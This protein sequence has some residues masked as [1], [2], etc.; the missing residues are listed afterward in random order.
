MQRIED[1]FRYF[2][3][4]LDDLKRPIHTYSTG[5]K[6]K[7]SFC[8]ANLHQPKLLLLDEPFNGLDP[9]TQKK[10]IT[11]LRSFRDQCKSILL[12][13]H[14]FSGLDQIITHVALLEQKQITFDDSIDA[15]LTNQSTNEWAEAL[16]AVF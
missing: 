11:F 5:M 9:E 2:F 15:F 7:L 10:A 3:D 14:F 16:N 4:N 13:S 12:T 6:K 8:A 1:L